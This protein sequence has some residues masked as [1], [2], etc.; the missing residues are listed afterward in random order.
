MASVHAQDLPS[1]AEKTEGMEQRDGFFPVYWDAAAGKVWLEIPQ[2]EQAFLYVNS[3]PVGLGSNDIGL[4]RGQLGGERVVYFERIGPKVHLVQPNLDYR[5]DTDNPMEAQAVTDAFAKSVLWGF[6]V[7]A[8]TGDRVLVD[9]TDFIVRDAH[10]IVRRL[11]QTDQGSF[12]LD[13][14]RSAPF[15]A[16]VKAFPQNTEMEARV[17]FTGTDPGRYVRDVAANPQS[18]TLRVRHSFVQLPDT[19]GYTP[20]RMDPRS[21]YF[22]LMYRDYAVPIGTD[23]TQRFINRHRLTC[24]EPPGA[25]GLCP[26]AEP[27]VY[28]LDPGTPEPVRSALL[29]G[30]RWWAEA[31]EAAGFENAYRVEM[32]PADADPMDVRY[33]TIQWVHRATRGWSYGSSVTDPRTGEIIKGHVTLGSLR[34]RQDYLLAEGMLAPY[35]GAHAEGFA[36]AND[37]MLAM[38][39]ARI[40]QL[41]AHEVGHTLGLAHNFAASVNDRASV[42]DYPAPLATVEDGQIVLDDAYDTGIGAWDKAAIRYGY[43]Q[44]AEGQTEAELL[45]SIIQSYQEDGLHYITDADARPAGAAHPLSNLWDNGADPVAALAREMEVREVA[46]DRFD[47]SVI[48]TGEPMALLEEALVPLYLRHRYQV[49]GTVKSIAGVRYSYALRGD[50]DATLPTPVD[51]SQQRDALDALLQTVTPQALRLPPEVRAQIAPRPPGYPENR[52]LFASHTEP[53]FDPYAPAEVAATMVLDLII[54]PERAARLAY[55]SDLDANLP[56]LRT[57][58]DEVTAAV[59]E[60]PVS[61][62]AYDA[63]LQRTVQQVWT[64]ALLEQAGNDDAAPAVQARLTQHLRDLHRWLQAHPGSDAETQAHRAQAH[65]MIGRFLS[66]DQSAATMPADIATPPGSPIG[67]AAPSYV[68]RQERRRAL[69]EAWAPERPACM[70]P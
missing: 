27:I 53:T 48:R 50:D 56:T 54:H 24:A 52:E 1:I 28:Y 15:P 30:A 37:P 18:F 65:A 10:G 64:D 13:A 31:F 41:S 63:E 2:M 29:D 57:V 34:V 55:Q 4:D 32:L 19:T 23:I 17:T 20:R 58:L 7:A 68:Q 6:E 44:P 33:N 69:L 49:E 26:V 21:G 61:G 5:A 12:S 47:A 62:N 40:R 42:M 8:A 70:V 67:S 43:A 25:D 35:D 46:L 14:S 9:A 38:A 45:D 3:L 59:W 39:L 60:A 11:Q 36:P 51:A 16:N 22:G 66:R